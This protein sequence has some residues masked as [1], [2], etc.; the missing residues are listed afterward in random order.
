MNSGNTRRTFF[1]QTL[2]GLG[3]MALGQTLLAR[4][5]FAQN[6]S[7]EMADWIYKLD[8]LG[9]ALAKGALSPRAWQQCMDGLYGSVNIAMFME[10]ID[11]DRLVASLV[12]GEK[13]EVFVAAPFSEAAQTPPILAV[14]TRFAGVKAGRCIAPHGHDNMVSAFLTVAGQFHVRQY[15]RIA[16]DEQTMT[17]RPTVDEL[18]NIGHWNSVSDDFNNLHWLK[19]TTQDSY[20][21]STKVT[22]INSGRVTRGRIPIDHRGEELGNEL[23][24][25]DKISFAR[26]QELYW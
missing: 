7:G 26:S 20:L 10:A 4:S 14:Q 22:G 2:C 25:V 9:D 19:A 8:G 16:E 17:I 23:M 1:H 13:G 18:S 11:F 12:Y 5:A 24:R 15:D 3:V 21:F 6:A